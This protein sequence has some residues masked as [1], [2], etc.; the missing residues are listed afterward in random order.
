MKLDF[1]L[2]P[3]LAALGVVFGDIGTSPLYAFQAGLTAA[4]PAG[5]HPGFAA[6]GVLS[7]ITWSLILVVSVKYVI[8]ILRADNEGEGG[9]LAL[10]TLLRTERWESRVTRILLWLGLIG[11]AMLFGDGV[12]T[13]AISVL[14][15]IEGLHVA[16]PAISNYVVPITIAVLFAVFWM[17]RRGVGPIARFYGPVMVAWFA[18]IGILGLMEV[19]RTPAVL[20]AVDPIHGIRL[21]AAVPG[22]SFAILGAVFLAVTGGE[23]LYADLG[24]FGRRTIRNAWF[25]VALPGLLLNYYGQGALILSGHPLNRPFFD[26]VPNGLGVPMVIL[27]TAATIIASQAILTGAFSLAQQAIELGFLPP[28]K[29]RYTSE[30]NESDVY[31]GRVNW[32]IAILAIG[33]VITFRTSDAL[34]AAYGI[35]VAITMVTTTILF[36]AVLILNRWT[37]VWLAVAFLVVFLAVDLPFATANFSKLLEGG[38]LPL[39]IGGGILLIM[40]AWRRGI[41]MLRAERLNDQT[42]LGAI[43]SREFPGHTIGQTAVFLTRSRDLAPEALVRMRKLARLAFR[44]TVVCSVRSTGQPRVP[45]AERYRFTRLGHDI[46]KIE[47][48]FGYMQRVNLPSVLVPILRSKGIDCDDVIYFVGADRVIVDEGAIG[49]GN[50]LNRIFSFL[51]DTAERPTDRYGLPETRTVS[52]GAGRRL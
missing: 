31:I 27:A 13:P 17:Q 8:F 48:F 21:F 1:R 26:L 46:V 41:A 15:A 24:Q 52:F 29:T 14:S 6:L 28:M 16:A 50:I 43:A 35:A 9:I 4:V 42:G 22:E 5:L 12:L 11:T 23:A 38:F 49:P 47:L 3:V 30:E 51:V 19:L 33:I 7:L 25:L 2:T 34:A 36:G 37:P 44:P 40:A 20:A 10:V 39:A 18:A 32:L 45:E